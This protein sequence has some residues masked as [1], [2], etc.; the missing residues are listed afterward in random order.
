MSLSTNRDKL[1]AK[2]ESD[3]ERNKKKNS[4]PE[5]YNNPV[6]D[7]IITQGKGDSYRVIPGW[8]SD[9]MTARFN[10]I[11]KRMATKNNSDG[12]EEAE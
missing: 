9:E 7:T 5:R 10:K 3:A 1:I 2:K 8:Y 12:K 4:T 6:K 11:F